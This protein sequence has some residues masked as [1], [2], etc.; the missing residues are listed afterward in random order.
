VS[1]V[2]GVVGVVQGGIHTQD[3]GLGG[4]WHSERDVCGAANVTLG[5]TNVTPYTWLADF[6]GVAMSPPSADDE[7]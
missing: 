7:V 3:E 2:T 5:A 6:H 1:V 4:G